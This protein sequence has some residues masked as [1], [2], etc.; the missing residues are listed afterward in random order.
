LICQ[1]NSEEFL[2]WTKISVVPITVTGKIEM[3]EENHEDFLMEEFWKL[4]G[5]C[6][7]R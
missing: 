6:S 7:S 4:L 1:I 5:S 2:Y 3:A